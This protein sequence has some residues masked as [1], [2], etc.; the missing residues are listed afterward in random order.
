MPAG[1]EAIFSSPVLMGRRELPHFP[2]P[3]IWA[4]IQQAGMVRLRP[5]RRLG[6]YVRHRLSKEGLR[7]RKFSYGGLNQIWSGA[8][9]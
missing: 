5:A 8:F 9:I 1:E 3:C 4:T 7:I 2:K 6:E